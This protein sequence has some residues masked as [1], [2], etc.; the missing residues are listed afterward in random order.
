MDNLKNT[1]KTEFL[2][3]VLVLVL[4][5]LVSFFSYVNYSLTRKM[6]TSITANNV[7]V[8]EKQLLDM[9]EKYKNC[10]SF[11]ISVGDNVYNLISTNCVNNYLS[12]LDN[13]LNQTLIQ[14]YNAGV[15]QGYVAAVYQILNNSAKCEPFNVFFENIS[16]DLINVA[17]LVSDNKK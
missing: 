3:M 5:F 4:V 10:E 15:N 13:Q 6:Y 1:V 11:N 12:L 14:Y 2:L 8:I 16:V 17:C 7:K 9:E